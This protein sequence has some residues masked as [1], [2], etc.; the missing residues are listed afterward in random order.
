MC[1]TLFLCCCVFLAV[2]QIKWYKS[3]AHSHKAPMAMYVFYNIEKSIFS[4]ITYPFEVIIMT[5]RSSR[6]AKTHLFG[7]S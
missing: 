6:W 2:L 4:A 3:E 7:P 1:A 5:N